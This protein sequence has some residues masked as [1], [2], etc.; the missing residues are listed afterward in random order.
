MTEP[1]LEQLSRF[2]PDSTGLD[3]DALLFA[4]GR[5]SVRPARAWKIVT[6]LLAA[7][8]LLTLVLLWPHREAAPLKEPALPTA[9]LVEPL[10]EPSE[11]GTLQHLL[12]AGTQELPPPAGVE[13]LAPPEPPLHAF[14]APPS[15]LLD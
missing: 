4:A 9:S 2:T 14:A 13:A 15:S 10:P 3:R 7:S 12:L 6:G 8:Q 5:A 11:E 1:F